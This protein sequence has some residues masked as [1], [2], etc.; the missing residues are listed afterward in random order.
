MD[1][2]DGALE[3][4]GPTG[5]SNVLHVMP[6]GTLL[7]LGPSADDV[8]AQRA[9]AEQAG[10]KADVAA[11]D[12]G[13]LVAWQGFDAVAWFGDAAGLKAVRQALSQR[14]GALLPILAGQEDIGRL[15]LERHVCIDTT[16]AGGN[17]S[18][19]ASAV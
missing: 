8:A 7:C 9:M 6:R 12:A 2:Q 17:A 18:L 13:R 19:M 10:C 14:A 5:E 1:L 3:L 16:A 11:F 15:Q 4:P